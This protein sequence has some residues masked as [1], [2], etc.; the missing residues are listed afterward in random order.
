LTEAS[1][2]IRFHGPF[3]PIAEYFE[4]FFPHQVGFEAAGRAAGDQLA[5]IDQ[6]Q[7]IAVFGLVHVVRRHE[8]RHASSR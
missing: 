7:T 5:T 2:S 8:D 6:A 1:V 3:R 4:H